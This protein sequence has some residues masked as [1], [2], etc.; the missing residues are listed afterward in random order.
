MRI[1]LLFLIFFTSLLNAAP[2]TLSGNPTSS[3]AA[4]GSPLAVS[5][6]QG[7]SISFIAPGT[8]TTQDYTFQWRIGSTNITGATDST[9][10]ISGANLTTA[11]NGIYSV[12]VTA[13]NGGQTQTST[14]ITLTVNPNIAPS[15]TQVA[16]IC[17]G[18]TLSALPTSSNNAPA[19]TGTWTP[20]LNNSTTT[21]YTFTPTAGQC[22]TTAT[23]IITV[24]TSVTPIF[25]LPNSIC[26]GSSVLTTLPTTSTNLIAGIWSPIFSNTNV[27]N[28]PYTFDPTPACAVNIIKQI[29]VIAN[30]NPTFSLPNSICSGSTAPLLPTTSTNGFIGTWSPSTVSNT[31]PTNSTFT[32]TTV[33]NPSTG[34]CATQL[35]ASISVVSTVTPTFNLPSSICTGSTAPLLPT[36]STNI[37]PISGVWNPSIVSNTNSNTYNFTPNA[38]AN[39]TTGQCGITTSQTI[40]VTNNVTPTFSFQTTICSG[41]TP[42]ALPTT[43]TNGI[44]GT[45]F[46]SII[47]TTTSQNYAFTPTGGCGNPVTIPITVTTTITPTFSFATTFCTGTTAPSLPLQSNNNII[48]TWN[49][50]T[51]NNTASQ[52]YIFTPN[53]GQCGVSVS[54]PITVSPNITLS[55]LSVPAQ[56]C[57]GST[58][59]AL[60]T[61]SNNSPAITGTWNPSIVSSTTLGTTPYTFTPNAGQCALSLQRQITVVTN[62]T[63]TFTLPSSI[64]SGTTAPILLSSSTNN[65]AITGT[66]NPA[67]AS[68]TILGTSIYTFTPNN[69][70]QCGS[71]FTYPLLVTSPVTIATPSII[72][73]P[74]PQSGNTLSLCDLG[75][76][77]LTAS[78]ATGGNGIFTYTL[79]KNGIVVGSSQSSPIFQFPSVSLASA[80][81][82]TILV[83]SLGCTSETSAIVLNVGSGNQGGTIALIGSSGNVNQIVCES[84]ISSLLGLQLVGSSGTSIAWQFSS[85]SNFS[86]FSSIGSNSTSLLAN[87]LNSPSFVGTRFFRAVLTTTGSLCPTSTSS[88]IAS[89]IINPNPTISA[90]NP[91]LI[92]VC[93]S[94]T[95]INQTVQVQTTGAPDQFSIDWA[96]GLTDIN[97]SSLIGGAFSLTIPSNVVASLTPYN[98]LVKVKVQATGCESQN[99]DEN[100][101]LRIKDTPVITSL[102]TIITPKCS[103]SNESI[104]I[105]INVNLYGQSYS[106]PNKPATIIFNVSPNIGSAS[107]SPN[108]PNNLNN[109]VVSI[110][111]PTTTPPTSSTTANVTVS[112]TVEGCSA[113]PNP[114]VPTL[115]TLSTVVVNPVPT[116]NSVTDILD[117]CNGTATTTINLSS[118][119]IANSVAFNYS[120]SPSANF[121]T[122]SQSNG[123]TS[124]SIAALNMIMSPA[125]GSS[126]QPVSLSVNSVVAS[127]ANS[128][129][130]TS[131]PQQNVLSFNVNP[132]PQVTP[133]TN[134]TPT[135]CSGTF[136][137]QTNFASNV[138]GSTFTWQLTPTPPN[139]IWTGITNINTQFVPQF[140]A[141]NNSDF[142]NTASIQVR[143]TANGCTSPSFVNYQIYTV[144]PKPIMVVNYNGSEVTNN[145]TLNPKPCNNASIQIA[146]NSQTVGGTGP[147]NFAWAR[148]F[149]TPPIATIAGSS[150]FLGISGS[151]QL[152]QLIG[153]NDPNATTD[154]QSTFTVT[155]SILLISTDTARCFG[156]PETFILA[157]RPGAR[158]NTL[159]DTIYEFCH[160]ATTEAI[161]LAFSPNSSL[162]SWDISNLSNIASGAISGVNATGNSISSVPQFTANNSNNSGNNPN[163]PEISNVNWNLSLSDGSCLTNGSFEIKVFSKP[164]V[165]V[166]EPDSTAAD[167]SDFF[168]ACTGVNEQIKFK[169]NLDN[170]NNFSWNWV[171]PA[172]GPNIGIIPVSQNPTNINLIN[173]SNILFFTAVNSIGASSI[174]SSPLKVF[175]QKN[176]CKS[177]SSIFRVKL[178]RL[179]DAPLISSFDDGTVCRNTRFQNFNINPPDLGDGFDYVWSSTV[180]TEPDTLGPYFI[181]NTTE[182]FSGPITVSAERLQPESG[183]RSLPSTLQVNVTTGNSISLQSDVQLVSGNGLICSNTDVDDS[184]NA[185]VWGFD[186][187]NTLQPF[188]DATS[189]GSQIYFP[190]NF[191]TLS[192]AYWVRTQKDGCFTKSYYNSG[193]ANTFLLEPVSIKEDELVAFNLF[194]N[195]S[196]GIFNILPAETAIGNYNFYLTDLTGRKIMSKI[197]HL[198]GSNP[199]QIDLNKEPKG[200]YFLTISNEN[201]V[202]THFKLIKN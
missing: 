32:Q 12:I 57:F 125:N 16:A 53:N 138:A 166:F 45:W 58:P 55:F 139:E 136:V 92:E 176:G 87:L 10:T 76:F 174:L 197:L 195:P 129:T 98:A 78:V 51:V 99:T 126:P 91:S 114:L 115:L 116:L 187:C 121:A 147:V 8:N 113:G 183:C 3:P 170:P 70:S 190:S 175:V 29:A 67:V 82:Y 122:P 194:P 156:D 189:Q 63:P 169:S 88:N 13:A 18:A 145:T 131:A 142:P 66:W 15:F 25:N 154:N 192:K 135:I 33:T 109:T 104:S 94:T 149:S 65:P 95:S 112:L 73:S 80:G 24:T 196:E 185:Y 102:G 188:V 86:T 153:N 6:C 54:I 119:T 158:F 68:N 22:A 59:P 101:V 75:S 193:C 143:A 133:S 161:S 200:L 184:P 40:T 171:S 1:L 152:P 38:I 168:F 90:I 181:L 79:K 118:P 46:P 124:G 81:S 151:G 117:V 128:A 178:F 11:D 132:I 52:S 69:P 37:P 2:F 164:K 60:P 77:S 110:P 61:S 180:L 177:D 23:M 41:S 9:L 42:S 17:S 144:R 160:S 198:S 182:N 140:T 43:S 103:N 96:T 108:N 150:T 30:I 7:G 4:S 199:I 50:S 146:Y 202:R 62:I 19:I 20:A 186:D 127:F 134:L 64:C 5:V 123:T 27:S 26:S 120:F 191:D 31:L 28:T 83:S 173:S 157:V 105:P 159:P 137:N 36:S 74:T 34:Q 130:C 165:D 71:V 89:V 49:P 48:G 201:T 39:P 93:K 47:N 97:N 172:V 85:T 21:T 35:N 167:E 179:P 106:G 148:S 162:L 141:N 44:S 155:P 100:L 84:N 56:I 107:L 14:T 72:S 111:N 163:L